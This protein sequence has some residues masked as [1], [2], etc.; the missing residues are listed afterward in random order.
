[1]NINERRRQS[2]DLYAGLPNR[3]LYLPRFEASE[4]KY[5][6]RVRESVLTNYYRQGI[7]HISSVL[8][9]MQFKKDSPLTLAQ[10]LNLGYNLH[11]FINVADI[12][13]QRDGGLY[14]DISDDNKLVHVTLNMFVTESKYRDVTGAYKTVAKEDLI[15]Y[16][17]HF[18]LP[19]PGDFIF[20]PLHMDLLETNL[21]WFRINSLYQAVLGY[22]S[23]PMI[24]RTRNQI[25]SNQKQEVLDFEAGNKMVEIAAGEELYFLGLDTSSVET[26]LTELTRLEEKMNEL[27]NSVL[28]IGI[29]PKTATEVNL[30]KAESMLTYSTLVQAK[31]ANVMRL[32]YSFYNKHYPE[33]TNSID[34]QITNPYSL[35]LD[36]LTEIDLA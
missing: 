35:E 30:I 23:K 8:A 18:G 22:Y 31:R 26:Q 21:A 7:S 24:V 19:E 32:M 17:Y 4:A 20:K 27:L 9:F 33:Y 5:Q 16:F 1:M 3:Y 14:I 25:I 29:M 28:S 15:P 11:N 10:D 12:I 2:I 6:Q 13:A 34:V 36:N